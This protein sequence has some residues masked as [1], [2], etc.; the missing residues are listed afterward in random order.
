RIIQDAVAYNPPSE[1]EGR[2]NLPSLF[3]PAR[4]KAEKISI[5]PDQSPAPPLGGKG[6]HAK[7]PLGEVVRRLR[8]GRMALGRASLPGVAQPRALPMPEGA[9]F[10]ARSFTCA[11]GTRSYRLYVPATHCRGLRGLIVMLHGCTQTPED[12]AAGT[13]MN[14]QAEKHRLLV[15]YPA[16]T[17]ADNAMS[18][19]NWF[20]PG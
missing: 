10:R 11:A 5:S 20:R 3:A 7:R 2:R 13:A 16:Q 6:Q 1:Q 8:E 15:A 17:A 19:W 4:A 9:Q 12:F 18:C 14:A